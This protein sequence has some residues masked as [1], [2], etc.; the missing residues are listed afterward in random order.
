MNTLAIL[1]AQ[2]QS[3]AAIEIILLLL[4]A[5]IIGYVTAWLY[6]KA[7]YSKKTAA[8]NSQNEE[9]RSKIEELE[10]DK[11]S[12][13]RNM[14][15]KEQE[16]ILLKEEFNA[17]KALHAETVHE[18][19]DLKLKNK[20]SKQLLHEKDKTLMA[21]AERKHLLDY[22]SFGKASDAEKDDLRMISGI[23]PFIEERLHAL[24][25][26]TYKQISKFTKKDIETINLAI[27]YF[28]GRIERDEWVAQAKELV[29]TE[30]ERLDLL[31][32]IRAKKTRIYFDRIGLAKKEEADDLTVI[33]GIGGWIKEKLNALDIYTYRQISKFNDEDMDIVTDAIEY[34]PG[35]IERDEWIHQ[36]QELVR[37]EVSKEELLKRISKMKNRIYYDRLGVASK[38]YANNLTLI[39]GIS[40]WIEERLNLL[41]IFTYEQISKLTPK[42]VT[43]ITEILDI[44]ED[45]IEKEKWIGQAD[46]L[47]KYQINKATKQEPVL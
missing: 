38:Q 33:N 21:I 20:K 42:D 19:D 40:S 7:I 29:R 1:L 2:T 25:I 5:V 45:R 10:A 13:K 39:K 34:F 28:S 26:F 8:I 46:E 36:A 47:V 37:A 4:G 3:A 35:R 17:F 14:Q 44:P 27:E 32:R 9:L 15:E 6:Y 41:D 18:T 31:E 43:I 23:G 24:D 16:M 22:T 30:K 11:G 12:L